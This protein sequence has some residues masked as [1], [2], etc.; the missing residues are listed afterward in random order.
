[1]AA[2]TPNRPAF[3][4]QPS[5]HSPTREVRISSAKVSRT[6]ARLCGQATGHANHPRLEVLL[7]F[8]TPGGRKE[9]KVKNAV[10]DSGAQITILL[11]SLLSQEGI[12]I[13]GLRRSQVDLRAAN[14]AKIEVQSVADATISALSPSRKRYRTTTTAYVVKNV[15]QVYL[16]L[17]VLVGLR[18]INEHFPTAG[19]GNQHGAQQGA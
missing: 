7:S 4:A 16:S 10:A 14:N 6:N 17:D 2:N 5:S 11:A 1:M 9:F 3:K 15:D 18:I 12:A 13:T 8:A 19:A